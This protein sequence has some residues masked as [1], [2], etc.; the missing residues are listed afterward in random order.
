MRVLCAVQT[1][2]G[3]VWPGW[4]VGVWSR[5]VFVQRDLCV[6]T[7]TLVFRLEKLPAGAVRLDSIS[8]RLSCRSLQSHRAC[9]ALFDG[10]A[11]MKW[12]YKARPAGR[13]GRSGIA[14]DARFE[15]AQLAW[16]RCHDCRLVELGGPTQHVAHS[17]MSVTRCWMV[18]RLTYRY[19]CRSPRVHFMAQRVPT[20]FVSAITARSSGLHLHIAVP[21]KEWCHWLLLPLVACMNVGGLGVWMSHIRDT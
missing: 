9:C 20:A 10:Y 1:A 12:S 4:S 18:T 14:V 17:P 7:C 16:F 3:L 5:H 13:H 15:G 19:T 2:P 21:R 6:R 8:Q 11:T